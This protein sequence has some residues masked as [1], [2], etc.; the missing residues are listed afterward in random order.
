MI[1]LPPLERFTDWSKWEKADWFVAG[2]ISLWAGSI[3]LRALLPPISSA[4]AQV[5]R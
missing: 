3:L 5:V 4:V 1:N 2:A